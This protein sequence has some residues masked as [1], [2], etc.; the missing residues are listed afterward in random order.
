MYLKINK[1]EER[2][3]IE[4][5]VIKAGSYRKLS[6]L[7]NIPRS[8]LLRYSQGGLIEDIRFK[9]L[10][11]FLNLNTFNE[12]IEEKLPN[13][14]RQIKGGKR[15][16]ESKKNKG[17][18]KA[19][20]KKWQEF[21]A[22]KLKKWHKFMKNKNPQEYYRIQYERFKK[23]GGYKYLTKKGE[24]VRN[25]LEKQ[26]ADKLYELK[27]E[28]QYEPL[29]N[30][31]KNYFFPDF[32]INEKIIIECT[33]WRGESKAYKLQEKIRYLNPKYKVYIVVPKTLYRYYKILNNHL[34]LGLDEFVPVA[35]TF[36]NIERSSR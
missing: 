15:L 36:K 2:R 28:Y 26:I 16:I 31:G 7:I 34:V 11:K 24:K 29:I 35:Q 23:V 22:K 6:K 5:A 14:W 1:S 27:I 33:M 4:K 19:E 25:I 21:Q 3:V 17:T 30:V 8:S 32:L 10:T 9:A 18:F 12:L 20:M 13:N